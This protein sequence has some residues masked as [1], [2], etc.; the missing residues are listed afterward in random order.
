MACMVEVEVEAA[1][2]VVEEEEEEGLQGLV[3]LTT[4]LTQC[5]TW[6]D[7]VGTPCSTI[8]MAPHLGYSHTILR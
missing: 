1:V 6:E 2:A 7:T 3:V 5:Q 4:S 8:Q